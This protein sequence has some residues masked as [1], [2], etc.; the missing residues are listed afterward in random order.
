MNATHPR[1]LLVS[2][3]LPPHRIGG[4]ELVVWRLAQRLTRQGWSVAVFCPTE[5][6]DSRPGELSRD[7]TDGTVRYT[8]GVPPGVDTCDD[9]ASAFGR[10][11][12]LWRPD[13]VWIHHLSG[14]SLRV[15]ELVLADGIPLAVT[16]HDYWWMCPRGQLLDGSARRC[17]GP[18]LQRC[19]DCMA[20]GAPLPLRP[21]TQRF[22]R[23]WMQRRDDRTK[24]ILLRARGLTAPS[25]HT[26]NRHRHWLGEDATVDVLPNPAPAARPVPLPPDGGPLRVGYFGSLLPSKGIETLLAAAARLPVGTIRLELHGAFPQGDQWRR[27]RQR[28][29]R[30]VAAGPAFLMGPY[31]P[32]EIEARM[33]GVEL[34]CLPSRWEENAPLVL[35]EARAI[36]RPVLASRIGGIP[37]FIQSSQV[38]VCLPPEDEDAWAESLAKTDR[39]RRIGK[40]MVT[41]SNPIATDGPVLER[42]IHK[43]CQR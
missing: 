3:G 6:A 27:W 10:T 43:W 22:T 19:A 18:D 12:G 33:G 5:V 7:D 32:A 25:G 26:A 31:P 4:A 14:L 2:H 21:L 20:P 9:A 41:G 37:E 15:P 36:C 13:V 1:L 30:R 40:K 39:W 16:F 29:R 34:V 24:G 17:D 23:R 42:T 11:L 35:Q 28:I 8:V 38:G